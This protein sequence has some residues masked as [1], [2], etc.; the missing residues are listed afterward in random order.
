[1]QVLEEAGSLV[2]TE[3]LQGNLDRILRMSTSRTSRE[4]EHGKEVLETWG[5][6]VSRDG[7]KKFADNTRA[8]AKDT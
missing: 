4:A 7:I 3:G 6:H 8:K 1:M 2:P 5:K